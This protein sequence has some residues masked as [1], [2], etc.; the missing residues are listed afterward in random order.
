L[1]V[2]TVVAERVFL[3]QKMRE[4]GFRVPVK[5]LSYA[6][7]DQASALAR[8]TEIGASSRLRDADDSRLAPATTLAFSFV[9]AEEVLKVST[10]SVRIAI[11][12]K[13]SSGKR[14]RFF[15]DI[16]DAL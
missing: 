9:N 7:T 3:E 8:L 16:A 6:R 14:D 4:C 12:R 5:H 10:L 1:R 13:S 11:I 15:E 2:E